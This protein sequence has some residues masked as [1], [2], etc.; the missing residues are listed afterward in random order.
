MG[1]AYERWEIQRGFRIRETAPA[2]RTFVDKSG[3][4]IGFIFCN[5]SIGRGQKVGKIPME[6]SLNELFPTTDESRLPEGVAQKSRNFS[7][8]MNILYVDSRSSALIVE[9][10]MMNTV[11]LHSVECL[12]NSFRRGTSDPVPRIEYQTCQSHF[13]EPFDQRC[14][15]P[16]YSLAGRLPSWEFQYARP[17]KT[18]ET[19]TEVA[20]YSSY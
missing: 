11:N 12:S 17:Y 20:G 14:I 5:R 6:E 19:C 4:S 7:N 18:N 15:K 16:P 8:G 9:R 3:I 1:R 2:G 13:R 10:G